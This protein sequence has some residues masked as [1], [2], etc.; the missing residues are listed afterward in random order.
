MLIKLQ[1]L[2]FL[3][4][5]VVLACIFVPAPVLASDKVFRNSLGMEF[6][7]IPEGTFIMGSPQ[8][9]P[10]RSK[11]EVQ[12][13]VTISRP[14]YM[15]TTEVTLKQW[16]SVMGKRFFGRRKGTDD[17]P[18]TRVSWHDCMKFI[19]KL[20]AQKEGVYRLPT[21]AEW[22]Y[23]CRAG[24]STAYS[25]GNRIDCTKAMYSNNS[26]KSGGCLKYIKSREMAVDGAATVKSYLPNAWGLYDM[27]GNVWEWCINWY[28][29]YPARAVTDPLGPDSGTG[30]IRRG[31]SWF[32]D[33]YLCRSAN[34]NIGHP[35]SRYRTT[36]F[37]LVRTESG[38]LIGK[39][40]ESDLIL[41][42]EEH[43]DGP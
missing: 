30:K 7:L 2:L 28:G 13:P 15:Q 3:F 27:H 6:V 31:G 11:S 14:F 42:E 9:E 38:D 19:K 16:W 18:V 36:G 22:E 12:H 4:F 8:D 10:H 20:N 39:K 17:M 34:R 37:R 43:K 29:D 25:W 24:T 32:G 40:E 21:E 33:E 1:K 23:A 26:S 5:I 41:M 35:A